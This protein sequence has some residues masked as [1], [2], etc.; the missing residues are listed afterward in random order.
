MEG[1]KKGSLHCRCM[2]LGKVKFKLE[3]GKKSRGMKNELPFG[4]VKAD[5]PVPS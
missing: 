5:N 1:G 2:G 3:T 4:T